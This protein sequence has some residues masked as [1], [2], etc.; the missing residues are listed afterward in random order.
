MMLISPQNE[1]R[2]IQSLLFKVVIHVIG[3]RQQRA[4]LK[5]KHNHASSCDII[6][7]PCH[8]NGIHNSI[9]LQVKQ[10][11]FSDG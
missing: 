1:E 11:S 10:L 3:N 5:E 2:R 9:R 6:Y 7:L 4:K 8:D